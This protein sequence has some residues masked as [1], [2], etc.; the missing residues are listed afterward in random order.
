MLADEHAAKDIRDQISLDEFQDSL[1]KEI[2][3]LFY[4]R[5]ADN[6]PVRLDQVLDHAVQPEVRSMLSEIGIAPVDFDAI[7]KATTDCI[8]KMKR[9]SRK[10]KIIELRKLRNE[11]EMAG[12][13]ERSRE[14]HNQAKEFQA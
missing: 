6:Q 14:L 2:A 10:P 3:K 9:R 8:E 7:P 12:Q 11:A 4:S 1:Y 13:T 5:I